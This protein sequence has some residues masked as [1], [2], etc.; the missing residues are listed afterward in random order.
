MNCLFAAVLWGG[1][2]GWSVCVLQAE[3]QPA[4][5]DAAEDEEQRAAEPRPGHPPDGHPAHSAHAAQG[6]ADAPA[7][8]AARVRRAAHTEAG[9]R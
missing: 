5:A 6:A 3:P 9:G 8:A 4:A 2:Q 7:A 1:E